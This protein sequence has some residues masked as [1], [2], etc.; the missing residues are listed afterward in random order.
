M[1]NILLG[2]VGFLGM[3][4]VA[5]I[6]GVRE[7]KFNKA[8][9]ERR[10]QREMRNK[11]KLQ[12]KRDQFEA[13]RRLIETYE[14]DCKECYE[15]DREQFG[16]CY[17]DYDESKPKA[18]EYYIKGQFTCPKRNGNLSSLSAR[19]NREV[20]TYFEVEKPIRNLRAHLSDFTV[21]EVASLYSII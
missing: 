11:V 12:A 17:P 14:K 3:V 16:K 2:G 13:F 10:K 15:Y 8:K 18:V 20:D 1:M 9:E 5:S 4:V 19:K 7:Y 21:G 6:L